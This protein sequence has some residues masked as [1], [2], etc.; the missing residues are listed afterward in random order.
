MSRRRATPVFPIFAIATL[1]L[2][3][4][5]CG[6]TQQTQKAQPG[7]GQVP[8]VPVSV[9]PVIQQS[10]PVQIAAVGRVEASAVIQVRSQIAGEIVRVAFIE[11]ANVK[12]DDLL[13]EI[14]PRPYQEA[15]RQAQA[16]LAR[17]TAQFHQAEANVERD[18]AQLKSAE[19]D[20]ERNRGLNQEGLASKAQSD[21]SI[22]AADALRAS[23]LA[24][25]AAT[26]SARA[27]LDNDRAAIDRAKL[28]LSYCE[29]RAPV[30]GRV[31][32]VLIHQGNLV[33][34][35]GN[36]L[37][38]I[39][40]VNP[41]WVSFNA[42]EQSL[43]EIRRSAAA[44]KLPVRAV[45]RDDVAHPAT[46]YLDVIDNTVDTTTGTI[47]LKAVFDNQ[48][49]GLFPGQ[50]ADVVLTLGTLDRA[51]LVPSEAV[52]AGVDGQ[53]VYVV[54]GNQ[55][56]EPRPVTVG[57]SFG[58]KVEIQK[59]LSAGESVVTD[60]QLRLFPGARIRAVPASQVDSQ[61]L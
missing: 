30:S 53:M 41:I 20:E 26:E 40:Q 44:R 22:A 21:Q 43:T 37:V 15:L 32:N 7:G 25:Q 11:G 54:K 24:D 31:G 50:F 60:G 55:T 38:V 57:S 28:D 56:V 5:G 47:H 19:A 45:P 2:L 13:F 3:T 52:Q 46:G 8:V 51:L 59:G 14:D 48:A 10:V 9:A 18:K 61:A 42:P 1:A 58:N 4:G 6:Q 17:D 39:N 36:P 16:T 34:A 12:K 35:N 23:I 29:I 27:A 49:G 33:G